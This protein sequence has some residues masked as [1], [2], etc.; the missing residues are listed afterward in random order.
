MGRSR[1]IFVVMTSSPS[2][3]QPYMAASRKYGA[4]FGTLLW[5][6]PKTQATRFK[7]LLQA[8]DIS[9]LAVMDVGCGRA[10]MLEYM[11]NRQR[12]P[13]SY[14]G[15]EAVEELALAAERKNLPNC[16]IIVGDFVEHPKLL[17]VGADVLFYSGSLNTMDDATFYSSI[18]AGFEAANRAIVFNFLSSPFL[19]G[20]S[21]LAWHAPEEVIEF[22][23][24]LSARVKLHDRYMRGDATV[25]IFK[26]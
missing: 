25:A 10:D 17:C 3:L 2:Y 26:D 24:G 12:Y 7:A 5:A 6:S 18:Q 13:L 23:K 16:K 20:S 8:V 21:H 22:A 19:A 4:G 1:T 11:F 9:N 15:V 14:T